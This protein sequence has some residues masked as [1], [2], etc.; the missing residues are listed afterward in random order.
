MKDRELHIPTPSDE[1]N[2][3]VSGNKFTENEN[4]SQQFAEQIKSS[5]LEESSLELLIKG[6]EILSSEISKLRQQ[7]NSKNEAIHK[8]LTSQILILKK[9]K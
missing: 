5:V 7:V 9:L 6:N 2:S 4:N 1:T 8:I 3:V